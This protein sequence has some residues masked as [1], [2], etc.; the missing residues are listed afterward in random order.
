M[1]ALW[2]KYW[3]GEYPLSSTFW[4]GLLG[5]V[6]VILILLIAFGPFLAYAFGFSFILTLNFIGATIAVVS[7]VAVWRSSG[8]YPGSSLLKYGARGISILWAGWLLSSLV[9]SSL[10]YVNAV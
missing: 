3:R 2:L 5:P 6:V 4:L 10:F 9:L 7:G 1:K 8:N